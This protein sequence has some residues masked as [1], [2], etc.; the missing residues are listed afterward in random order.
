MTSDGFCVSVDL[1][2]EF[3]Q[4]KITLPLGFDL[5]LEG[6]ILPNPGDISGRMLAQANAALAPFSPIFDIVDLALVLV[7]LFNALKKIPNLAKFTGLLPKLKVRVDKLKKLIP[8]L[9][10]P[11]SIKSII[12]VLIVFLLGLKLEIEAIIKAQAQIDLSRQRAIALGLADLALSLDCSQAN[13]DF[14]LDLAFANT[15]PLNRFINTINVF[16]DVAGID[17]I[18]PLVLDPGA[19]ASGAVA[20]IDDLI[21]RLEKLRDAVPV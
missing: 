6:P 7:E 5:E 9:S 21:R 20:P 3:L 11:T 12:Q 2:I 15:A 1:D 17:G 14:Q 16:C 4:L 19:G 18:P 10:V 13:L 8:Q